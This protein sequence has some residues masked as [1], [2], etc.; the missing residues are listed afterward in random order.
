MTLLNFIADHFVEFIIFLILFG[1]SIGG[2]FRWLIQQALKHREQM[3]DKRNEELRLLIEL[4]QSRASRA[5]QSGASPKEAAWSDP[6]ET[7]YETGYQQI[8][9]QQS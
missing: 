5:R 2:A 6:V 4:E 1:G 3:Q 7:P 9:Q 8:T